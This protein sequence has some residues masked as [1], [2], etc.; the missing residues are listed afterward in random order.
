MNVSE[1]LKL[2]LRMGTAATLMLAL[3]AFQ[4]PA[5]AQDQS[6][7]TDEDV[8]ESV[9]EV[10]VTGS[11]LRKN[12]F[13]S[14]SPLQI[15]SGEVSRDLGL[16]DAAAV[17]QQTTQATGLQVN[18]TFS[19]FVLDNGVGSSTLSF[20]GLGPDRTLVLI[21]GRRFAP[22][23]VGGGPSAPDINLI[24]SVLVSSYENLFD[25]AAAVY[26]SD[27]VA[28]VSNVILRSDVEGF[29]AEASY[30]IPESGGG[31]EMT[32][33]VLWGDRGDRWNF[34]VAAEYYDRKAQT[35]GE[36]DFFNSCDEYHFV[37]ESGNLL[38]EN[39]SG[40]SGSTVP[41]NG[42]TSCPTS[43]YN[44]IIE[45]SGFLGSVYYTPGFTN[46]N[47]P[48]WS[49]TT[50]SAGL[51]GFVDQST[52]IYYDTDGDGI[53]D[54]AA[55][56]ADGDGAVDVK[57]TDPRYNY[58]L[59]DEAF[60]GHL[61]SGLERYS[62]YA[63]GGYVIDEDNDIEAYAEFM[64]TRRESEAFSPGAQLF[65]VV[66]ADNPFNPFGVNG[67][68]AW[69]VFPAFEYGVPVTAQPV[70]IIPGDRDI[71]IAEVEQYRSVFGLR[72]NIAAMDNFMGGNWAFD[73]YG[74]YSR[75]NGDELTRGLD[76]ER[77]ELS[78]T[79]TREDPNNPGSYICGD[80]TDGC[81][82]VNFFADSLYQ[83]GGGSFATQAETDY[84]FT[85]RT[86]RTEIE[87]TI[88]NG[89][90]TGDTFTIP[91]TDEAVPLLVGAEYR[92]D[93]INST[94]NL[95]ASEGGLENFFSDRGAVG[96]RDFFEVFAETSL[97]LIKDKPMMELFEI[98]L[99]GRVTNESFFDPAFTYSIK[100]QAV[101]NDM[102]TLRGTYG[103]SYR[104]PNL[105]ER[106]LLGT[107]GFSSVTDPCVVPTDARTSDPST[108]SIQQF[109]DASGDNRDP[110]IIAACQGNGLDPFSLGLDDGTGNAFNPLGSTESSTGGS[111]DVQEERSKSY[112]FG[113]VFSQPFSDAFDLQLSA[114]YFS[115]EI[116]GG[117]NE[118]TNTF[119]VDQCYDNVDA[120]NG[121]SAFCD[122]I[123]R[124]GDGQIDF[125]TRNFLNFG[126]E[127]AKGIELNLLYRQDFEVGNDALGVTLDL[128]ATNTREVFSDLLGVQDD[129]AG[130]IDTP[131]WRAQATL[132]LTYKDFGLTWNTRWIQG[133][134]EDDPTGFA[135]G[136]ACPDITGP[137]C[138][139]ISWTTNYDVHSASMTYTH[140]EDFI[141][142]VGV[143]NIFHTS[144][145][146]V[147]S[148]DV[149]SVNL[150]PIGVGYDNVGRTFFAS[151][152][153]KF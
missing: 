146:K 112:T 150:N 19:G 55:F 69:A 2:R 34:T 38:T 33:G 50:F 90:I 78:L 98:D 4:A 140:N 99:A 53:D 5:M 115:I 54:R 145:P 136:T 15:I 100:G 27:A 61:L 94:G 131:K 77:L 102:I 129:D 11:R 119:I 114:T 45:G 7:D 32:V 48:D 64:Y 3:G 139:P 97:T 23:G 118:P 123:S 12:T 40:T 37:D 75:S 66:P 96:S 67:S 126:L 39:K 138:R 84:L 79:T 46:I 72:G 151:V 141:F 144:P 1:S 147:D 128:R 86:F 113:A 29:E 30:S 143:R 14:P 137:Q 116:E 111:Q 106:F 52:V 93:K 56:D 92:K 74:S 44:R 109:Y 80:G 13:T 149:F 58:A 57:F 124:D 110:N 142:N 35:F 117:V 103:T 91:W 17:L 82:P 43:A 16:F 127:T 8:E 21:N 130:E 135:H 121:D 65:P 36:N 104:A 105:R 26:G 28:G 83:T 101:L 108:G 70:V 107:T 132:F 88:I 25:G 51:A 133:G 6:A 87:Q 24:P 71:R 76:A 47:V 49:D 125:I 134:I 85:D 89:V 73:I 68:D 148:T 81:V 59:T 22:A 20:R 122:L 42:A 9:E 60:S 41:G 62:I 153:A 10:V 31:Q 152:R 95:I 120:P 63:D 18:N